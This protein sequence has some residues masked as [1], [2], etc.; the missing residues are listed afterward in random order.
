MRLERE[1]ANEE[2]ELEM[3]SRK[4][5]EMEGNLRELDDYLAVS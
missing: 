4:V 2:S 1:K 3:D 5:A